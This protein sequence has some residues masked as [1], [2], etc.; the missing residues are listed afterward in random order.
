MGRVSRVKYRYGHVIAAVL[1]IADSLFNRDTGE[2][3]HFLS[4]PGKTIKDGGFSGIGI[5]GQSD[6]K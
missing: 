4:G 5:A 2:I 6:F 1:F 3:G